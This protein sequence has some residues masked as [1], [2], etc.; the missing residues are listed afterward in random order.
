M[1]KEIL[2]WYLDYIDRKRLDE[3]INRASVSIKGFTSK[4]TVSSIP[5]Q[6]AKKIC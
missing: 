4:K 2:K 3:I 1:N 6:L 5:T